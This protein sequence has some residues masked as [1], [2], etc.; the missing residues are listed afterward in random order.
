MRVIRKCRTSLRVGKQESVK[1]GIVPRKVCTLR[2]RTVSER[3]TVPRGLCMESASRF[4]SF[5]LVSE[6]LL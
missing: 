6:T 4:E 1:L 2:Y 5:G 3:A